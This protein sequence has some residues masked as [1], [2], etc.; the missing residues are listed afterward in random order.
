MSWF[1][2]LSFTRDIKKKKKNIVS[3]SSEKNVTKNILGG[4]FR[5]F[6][7]N[8]EFLTFLVYKS[9]F[10]KNKDILNTEQI[11]FLNVF[12]LGEYDI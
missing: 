12:R 5:N 3:N 1:F 2:F 6:K 9:S 10:F 4:N 7:I 11:Y 8:I